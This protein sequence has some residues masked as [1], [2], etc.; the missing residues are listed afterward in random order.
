MNKAVADTGPLLHLKEI[1]KLSLLS[2]FTLKLRRAVVMARRQVTGSVGIIV[3]GYRQKYLSYGEMVT[4]MD[5]LFNDSSLYLSRSFKN[6]V[7]ELVR[8]LEEESS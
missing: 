3:R 8:E 5:R 6:R 1:N 2:L 7:L 4:A